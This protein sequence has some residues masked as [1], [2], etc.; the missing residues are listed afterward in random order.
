MY[1]HLVTPLVDTVESFHHR[2]S[3]SGIKVNPIWGSRQLLKWQIFCPWLCS[4]SLQAFCDDVKPFFFQGIVY[5]YWLK[6]GTQPN[7]WSRKYRFAKYRHQILSMFGKIVLLSETL[8]WNAVSRH[9]W[10]ATT[11]KP[12]NPHIIPVRSNNLL[13]L[14]THYL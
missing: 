14:G 8:T 12:T 2:V 4:Y 5:L 6:D 3:P 10:E 9:V 13:T 1:L 7:F 11:D